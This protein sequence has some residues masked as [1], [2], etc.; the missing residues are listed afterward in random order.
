MGQ[1]AADTLKVFVGTKLNVIILAYRYWKTACSTRSRRSS[2]RRAHRVI[3]DSKEVQ[4]QKTHVVQL[5]ARR[6]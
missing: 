4:L 5:E 1:T 3:E 2:P 6:A